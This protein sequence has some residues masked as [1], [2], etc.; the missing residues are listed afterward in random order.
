MTK[1][2]TI[3]FISAPA[4]FDPAPSEF[5][6]VIVEEVRTQQAPLLLPE[7][8][9]RLESIAS[10]QN[11]LNLCARSLKAMGC[12]V[13]A[14]VGSPFAWAKATSEAE[15]RS[16]NKAMMTAAHV[17]T[18]MT[19]LAIVD[20]LRTLDVNKIAVDCTYYDSDWRDGF[21][22]FLRLCGFNIIH[23]STLAEQGLIAPSTKMED[24][25]WS[26]T[27][28]LASKS[29]LFVAE[30]SPEAEAIVV[31]GAG[32]RTLDILADMEAQTKRPIIAADTILYW[33]IARELDLTLLPVMGSL[34]NLI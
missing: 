9:Y 6:N 14:Q 8:D 20:G 23:V 28:E 31:T 11:E 25:G 32:T 16:R 34:S 27:P 15:A 4:W 33:A 7:F 18:L 13:V 2:Q 29:I 17:P 1:I 21:S 3:G 24:I 22:A 12:D 10:V 30:S 5:S 19:G 26:M